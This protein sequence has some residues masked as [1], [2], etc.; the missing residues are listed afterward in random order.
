VKELA[1]KV[2]ICLAAGGAVSFVLYFIFSGLGMDGAARAFLGIFI[3]AWLV[4]LA[5]VGT[6][7]YGKMYSYPV[8][9]ERRDK[10]AAMPYA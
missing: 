3:L 9:Y 1:K 5:W 7:V 2:A 6:T 8:E 4:A 10:D